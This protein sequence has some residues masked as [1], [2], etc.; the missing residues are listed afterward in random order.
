[1]L[2]PIILFPT[3]SVCFVWCWK[4]YCDTVMTFLSLSWKCYWHSNDLLHVPVDYRAICQHFISLSINLSPASQTFT[5]MKFKQIQYIALTQLLFSVGAS[6]ANPFWPREGFLW[7]MLSLLSQGRSRSLCARL[8]MISC[9]LIC[10]SLSWEF[11]L[12]PSRSVQFPNYWRGICPWVSKQS[13]YTCGR[14]RKCLAGKG[15]V[16][17]S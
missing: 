2:P 11:T 13:L 1:M 8:G 17:L 6:R 5:G 14:V 10:N 9:L 3:C 4:I 12:K 15:G 7:P 16:G